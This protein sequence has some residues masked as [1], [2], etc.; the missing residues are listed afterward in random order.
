MVSTLVQILW[1]D[2]CAA[3]G[4]REVRPLGAVLTLQWTARCRVCK[5]C[6]LY[7]GHGSIYRKTWHPLI[8]FFIFFSLLPRVTGLSNHKR[9]LNCLLPTI[10]CR[11]DVTLQCPCYVRGEG[12]C[13]ATLQGKCYKCKL[14]K[15]CNVRM[16]FYIYLRI[17]MSPTWTNSQMF[18]RTS[19]MSAILT[20]T[21]DVCSW[22]EISEPGPTHFSRKSPN[23]GTSLITRRPES[24][25]ESE[26]LNLSSRQSVYTQV[27][28]SPTKTVEVGWDEITF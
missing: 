2:L 6:E 13:K 27:N 16:N 24:N 21:L 5:L 17:F 25:G 22:S 26:V 28:S 18:W 12:C 9:L 11:D 8:H 14:W 15:H 3:I 23:E 19:W 7:L 10:L 20:R 4:D 1:M